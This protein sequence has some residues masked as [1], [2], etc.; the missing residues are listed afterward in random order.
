M[1]LTDE[2]VIASSDRQRGQRTGSTF[3][4]VVQDAP[5]S[6]LIRLT[7]S[8]FLGRK[9]KKKKKKKEEEWH[10]INP[11]DFAKKE[12]NLSLSFLRS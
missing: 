4:F 12:V 7:V 6:F 11:F 2:V 9:K 8:M 3:L 1:P 5:G 10:V